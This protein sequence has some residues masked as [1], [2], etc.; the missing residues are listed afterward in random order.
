M[1]MAELDRFYSRLSARCAQLLGGLQHRAF[2]TEW[3]WYSG[4]YR[5]GLDG[6]YH[7]DCYPIPVI[8]VRGLCDIEIQTD[9]VNVTA[10]RRRS[11]VLEGDLGKLAA[12]PFEAYGV[13][14]YLADYCGPGMSL[15]Q[16]RENVAKSAER[17]IGFA[18]RF[19]FEVGG[20]Q[21]YEFAKL[22]RREGF[23]Y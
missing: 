6:A 3:G 1:D 11:D 17:E 23:Y 22:L 12:Y 14:D 5:K 21:M 8:S 7:M 2:E 4:H 9:E 10:K 20:E 15:E 13:E 19:D 16:F 18:F